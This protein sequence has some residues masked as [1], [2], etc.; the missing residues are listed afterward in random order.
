M[1]STSYKIYCVDD[2]ADVLESIELLIQ[3]AGYEIETFG[4]AQ[5]FLDAVPLNS[6]GCLILDVC[7]PGM[8]G[9]TLQKTL[10]EVRSGLQVIF[11]SGGSKLGD[12]SHAMEAG[13]LGYLQKPF[14]DEALLQLIEKAIKKDSETTRGACRNC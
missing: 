10:R 11:I 12:R 3:S 13:A 9:F 14:D 2:D 1:N 7:M 5:M 8:D 6:R 4:S